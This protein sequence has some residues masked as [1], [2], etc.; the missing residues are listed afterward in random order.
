MCSISAINGCNY[1]A[2]VRV[3]NAALARHHIQRHEMVH[4]RYKIC[5]FVFS[6][7]KMKAARSK[8]EGR[9][10]KSPD[11]RV[12]NLRTDK[13]H[14]AEEEMTQGEKGVVADVRVHQAIE[15]RPR[16]PIEFF[17]R[18]RTRELN[19]RRFA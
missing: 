1:A 4:E 16:A 17:L 7:S 8:C 14:V 13:I 5:S 10:E 2:Y 18:D 6:R 9:S 11:E 3:V 19:S 15:R 12:T